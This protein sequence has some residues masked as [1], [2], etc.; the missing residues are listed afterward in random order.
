MDQNTTP[1]INN[2]HVE[3]LSSIWAFIVKNGL[4]IASVVFGVTA[5]VYIIRRQAKRVTRNQCLISVFMA[6]LAGVIGWYLVSE[7]PLKDF[8]KAII[9]GYLPIVIE[10][11][12]LRLIVWIDPLID[13]IGKTLK[14]WIKRQNK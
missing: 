8:W 11:L 12:T 6:G 4:G 3:I 5:K 13:E 14:S 1:K 7:M 9:C 2:D 10:P